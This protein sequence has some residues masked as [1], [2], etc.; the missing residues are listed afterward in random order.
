MK[1]EA[2]RAEEAK[3]RKDE[4][5]ERVGRKEERLKTED[6]LAE[7]LGNQL[8]ETNKNKRGRRRRSLT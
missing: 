3:G 6:E 5:E 7:E 2:H 4:D 8:W 1:D